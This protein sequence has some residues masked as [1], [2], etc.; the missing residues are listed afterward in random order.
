MLNDTQSALTPTNNNDNT[1][2]SPKWLIFGVI[3]IVLF[4]ITL[5][6]VILFLFRRKLF[7]K[8]MSGD[9]ESSTDN[10]DQREAEVHERRKKNDDTVIEEEVVEMTVDVE[11]LDKSSSSQH[12][13]FDIS[14]TRYIEDPTKQKMIER[15]DPNQTYDYAVTKIS[16]ARGNQTY[17]YVDLETIKKLSSQN[18]TGYVNEEREVIDKTQTDKTQTFV[19]KTRKKKLQQS[20]PKVGKSDE[21]MKSETKGAFETSKR[22]VGKEKT[23]RAERGANNSKKDCVNPL[24][25]KVDVNRSTEMTSQSDVY[26]DMNQTSCCQSQIEQHSEKRK[27]SGPRHNEL[28]S[29][30]YKSSPNIQ[31]NYENV[32]LRQA[33]SN[34]KGIEGEN[35]ESDYANISDTS[36]TSSVSTDSNAT[37]SSISSNELYGNT[38]IYKAKKVNIIKMYSVN[39]EM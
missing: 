24:K 21:T 13:N 5:V 14:K 17:D 22:P 23:H 26:M 1:T 19:D 33:D 11:I 9:S 34:E 18:D 35:L 31:Q 16:D 20:A 27:T 10:I 25:K 3:G 29:Y 12:G 36:P 39:D 38:I 7:T 15:K 4:V 37:D 30:G 2:E 6:I 8:C 28:G 32:I